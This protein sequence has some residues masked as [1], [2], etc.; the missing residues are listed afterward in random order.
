[1]GWVR[2]CWMLLLSICL[3]ASAAAYPYVVDRYRVEMAL[4]PS[5]NIKVT[6]I[7][8]VTFNETR[9][10]IFRTIPVDYEDGK[11][12]L[13]RA[14]LSDFS[15][16][17]GSGRSL[18]TKITKEGPNVK[19]RIGDEKIWLPQGTR[20][21]YIIRYNAYGVLNWFEAATSD[22]GKPNVELYWNAI[23][24]QWDT[25]IS[26]AEVT[27]RFPEVASAT[28]ARARVFTGRY[29]GRDQITMSRAGESAEATEFGLSAKL[30]T[31]ALV[32]QRTKPLEPLEGLTLVLALPEALVPRPT[33]TQSASIFLRTN[34]GYLLPLLGLLVMLPL[35]YFRGR[36]PAGGPMVVQFDPP[37]FLTA[38]ECGALVDDRADQ[39][40]IAA[41]I[42]ALA[43]YGY[44]TIE[45][46]EEGLIFKKRTATLHLTGKTGSPAS[47]FEAALLAKLRQ[48]PSGPITENE[49]RT[50]VAPGIATLKKT[51]FD[52]LVKRGF[53]R[54]NP[55][56]V[57]GGYTGCGCIIAIAAAVA[58]VAIT[59]LRVPLP[60]IVGGVGLLIVVLGFGALMSRRTPL[61][62]KTRMKVV[63][64]EE[65]IRR[66]RGH[67]LE[68]I[69]K[70]EPTTALFE[71]YLPFAV[72]FGL[73]Q[74]WAAAFEGI[75]HEMPH[76]YHAPPGTGF[77]PGYFASDLVSVNSALSSAAT[78]PPRSSGG[79]G[80]SSGFGGGGFSG[81]G[82]GGGGGGSW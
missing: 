21:T 51:L 33:F 74:E 23:G 82:F 60:G 3:V 14:F 77:H 46:K 59:P 56:D 26:R 65:F 79:S 32:V 20:M 16:A 10:G 50:H 39:R 48:C 62:A 72:A 45:P 18:T 7:L 68:W 15:V 24:D 66:A 67:E 1:M 12:Q 73:T 75:L 19:I 71:E 36:D 11:G 55:I 17:D 80:G 57:V 28:D 2:A 61:G 47:P 13:R 30:T 58:T 43:V 6:E 25:E 4:D 40:D 41:G 64:F 69:S 29:G 9:R 35:W 8:D 54:R 37:D 49:L 22:W 76:W 34:F 5:G 78:T 27:V 70:K 52:A 38:S 81:G 63:G 53:Y 31:D 44:L 42:I